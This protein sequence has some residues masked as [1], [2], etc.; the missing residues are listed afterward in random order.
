MLKNHRK[1]FFYQ[2]PVNKVM[3]PEFVKFVKQTKKQKMSSNTS[4]FKHITLNEI[5]FQQNHILNGFILTVTLIDIPSCN[6]TDSV[7]FV[8]QDKCNFVYKLSVYNL[9]ND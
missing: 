8:I 9:G 1:K 7:D 3:K 6:G 5:D 2:I 4:E